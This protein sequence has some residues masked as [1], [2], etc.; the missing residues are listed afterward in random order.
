VQVTWDLFISVVPLNT[1]LA[2]PMGYWTCLTD[3]SL[4]LLAVELK[5]NKSFVLR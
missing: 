3:R 4:I 5:G 1:D 2:A